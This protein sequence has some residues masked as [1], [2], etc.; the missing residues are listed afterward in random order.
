[1]AV[2]TASELTELRQ[3]YAREIAAITVTKAQINAAMQA[4]EDTFGGAPLQNAL[5]DAID[6]AI[7]PATMT[8]AQKRQLV[9]YWLRSRF[10]RGN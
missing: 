3:G 9:K 2:L 5:S 8:N 6:T 4:V 10:D 1:M 7:A